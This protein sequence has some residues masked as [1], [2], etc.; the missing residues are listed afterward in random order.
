LYTASLTYYASDGPDTEAEAHVLKLSVRPFVH[1]S[2]Y[3]QICE[4]DILKT[5]EPISVTIGARP[6]MINFGGK[7][8]KGHTLPKIDLEA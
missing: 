5:N 8:G 3:H 1:S 2:M 7:E 6:Q 4:H